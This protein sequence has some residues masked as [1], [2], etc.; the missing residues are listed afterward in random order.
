MIQIIKATNY[1]NWYFV[2]EIY[3]NITFII[4]FLKVIKEIFEKILGYS[5]KDD[6]KSINTNLF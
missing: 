3:N 1:R 5:L 6:G 2:I 4:K